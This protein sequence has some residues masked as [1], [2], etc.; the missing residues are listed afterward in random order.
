MA[1]IKTR[2][3]SRQ[4]TK[5]M[6][7]HSMKKHSMK[8]HSMKKHS[9]KKHS[10]KRYLKKTMKGGSKG[11]KGP[12]G[13]HKIYE[14]QIKKPKHPEGFFRKKKATP[15]AMQQYQLNLSKYHE[16]QN[17]RKAIKKGNYFPVTY[18]VPTN[19]TVT[20]SEKKKWSIPLEEE[21]Y[22]HTN[23][24]GN[25]WD[26][27]FPTYTTV[28]QKETVTNNKGNKW[29]IPLVEL[30]ESKRNKTAKLEA[31]TK[32]LNNYMKELQPK[33][34][35]AS[36]NTESNEVK[37]N[38]LFNFNKNPSENTYSKLVDLSGRSP[39]MFEGGPRDRSPT[40][41]MTGLP[42]APTPLKK[43][44]NPYNSL[45]RE[46][47]FSKPKQV[48]STPRREEEIVYLAS[49]PGPPGSPGPIEPIYAVV[50]K[51]TNS[52]S[53]NPSV[54]SKLS[55]ESGYA[56][57]A[58]D[59]LPPIPARP[60]RPAMYPPTN[61]PSSSTPNSGK[62]IYIK[63]PPPGQESIYSVPNIANKPNEP[64][65]KRVLSR[66]DRGLEPY[67]QNSPP[68]FD[69]YSSLPSTLI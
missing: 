3:Q 44:L 59:I 2:K 31:E 42:G 29:I 9:M 30:G 38:P 33:E 45:R 63:S 46:T 6:K 16:Q 18:L 19:S 68:A 65:Y 28:Q 14:E 62:I 69:P 35:L 24:S 61:L 4:N 21:K 12:K 10:M 25:T 13:P 64:I 40:M 56:S 20:N 49:P 34:L 5:S 23:K 48:T 51:P 67:T 55:V 32:I 39:T 47:L 57:G 17:T 36:T 41:W 60:A 58:N 66:K 27:P 52:L 50:K 37:V 22:T 53:R 8:K 11:P 26:I 43:E 54:T 1:I 7:K 15:E